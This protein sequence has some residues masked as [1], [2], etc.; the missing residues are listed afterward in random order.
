MVDINIQ[1][2]IA[3][4]VRNNVETYLQNTDLSAVI[5]DT[6]QKQINNVVINLTGRVY[7][8]ITTKRDFADE[9]TQLVKGI[10]LDQ[11][12]D[13]GTKQI[14]EHLQGA[15]LNRVI[16]SSV[17]SE[18]NRAASNYNFPAR[19]I[20]F[21][22]I[23]MD[24]NEFNAGWINNGIYKNFT[25]TGIKDTASKIQLEVTDDG[26]ITTNSITAENL[27]VEDNAFLKNVTIDGDL[28][29]T[30]NVLESP[31]L[32]NYIQQVSHTT[33]KQN[34]DNVNSQ[35]INIENRAII[36]GDK[37]V[38]GNNSLGPH[39]INSNLR[40]V[41]NL[42]ELVVSGQALI[43]D[44]LVVNSGHVGIN[45][46]ETPGV[47]SIW[48]QDSELSILK[49]AQKN[50]FVGSTRQ[51]DITLGSNNQN[52]IVLKTDNIIE[53]NGKIRWNGLLLDIVDRIPEH[54]GEPNEIAILRDGSAIYSCRG[55]NSWGKIL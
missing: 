14:A 8:E 47:L 9:V 50:M 5:A 18:V 41:G 7:N 53:L 52:Q 33:S 42:N 38:L 25:S 35:H 24:G 55:Q 12:V 11:L 4:S 39:I 29:L 31:S 44:T 30:G 13:I 46:E 32:T 34:I 26:I 21:E 54:I 15:D 1:E 3:Q 22:S 23:R 36:D 45:T 40:K 27:L 28:L 48:D 51:N 20:S 17:Q 2:A 16:V 10:I 49:Y 43:G 6:L 37:H 19:S